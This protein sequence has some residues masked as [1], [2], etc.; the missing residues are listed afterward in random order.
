LGRLIQV[1]PELASKNPP[2]TASLLAIEAAWNDRIKVLPDAMV[3]AKSSAEFRLG[4]QAF[5]QLWKLATDYWVAIQEGG[6]VKARG[7]FGSTYAAQEKKSLTKFGVAKRTFDV[8]GEPVFMEQHLRIGT[9]ANSADTL[10][11][12]FRWLP[13]SKMIVIGYCGRHLD[14]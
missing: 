5:D 4:E 14:F 6:D 12:H 10:R 7:V 11:I 13:K 1:L 9:A 3:S 8:D 2:L